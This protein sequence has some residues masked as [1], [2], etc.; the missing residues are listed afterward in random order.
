MF[1]S[2]LVTCDILWGTL[3]ANLQEIE[4]Q[5]KCVNS[6]YIA[7][8]LCTHRLQKWGKLYPR[9]HWLRR[10]ARKSNDGLPDS[11]YSVHIHLHVAIQQVKDSFEY[12]G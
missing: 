11:F 10:H 7:L 9:T 2:P 1:V 3:A 6:I 8:Y 5:F 12:D 4:C